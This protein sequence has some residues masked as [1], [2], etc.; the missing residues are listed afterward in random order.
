MICLHMFQ[1]TVKTEQ[2]NLLCYTYDVHI[3][4]SYIVPLVKMCVGE[5][6][7]KTLFR[8]SLNMLLFRHMQQFLMCCISPDIV[9]PS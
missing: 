1:E 3:Q 9:F 5:K 2:Q 8:F 4:V 6:N 7:K